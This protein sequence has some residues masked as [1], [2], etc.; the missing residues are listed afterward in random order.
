MSKGAESLVGP[1]VKS[2]VFIAVTVLTTALLALTIVNGSTG[3]GHTY[4][5]VFSDATQLEA[6][7]DVRMAGVRIGQVQS[8]SVYHRRDALVSFTLPANRRLARTVSASIRFRNLIGQRYVELDQGSGS[9][10]DPLP[11]DST[12]PLGR[13]HDALDLTVLFNGFQPLFS[14]LQPKQVN[15]L[16]GEIIEVFQGEG[17]TIGNLLTQTATLTNS[18]ADKDTVITRVIHNLNSVLDVVNARRGQLGAL[19][20]SLRQL[21]SGLS[22]DRST[23]GS[24]ISGIAGLTNSVSGLLRQGRAPLKNSIDALGQVSAT[25]AGSSGALNSFLE[26]LPVKLNRIGRTASYGSWL[27][28][29]LCSVGGRIPV[30]TDGSGDPA[31][32]R[33]TNSGTLNAKGL[34]GVRP[35]TRRCNA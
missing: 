19:I 16:S 1:V 7:D 30:P 28:F 6:G 15:Q 24:S 27:N 17:P 10:G 25:L 2:L 4:R 13:T 35:E 22:A 5:A 26:K 33:I 31:Y 12:I 20:G 3:G 14:A 23:L 34:V 9:L 21:V 29:Y 32:G 11:N 18:I 8:V